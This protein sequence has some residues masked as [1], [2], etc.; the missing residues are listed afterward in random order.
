VNAQSCVPRGLQKRWSHKIL[1]GVNGRG[2]E[3]VR[4]H[5]Q[6]FQFF[7]EKADRN[8]RRKQP[9]F[10]PVECGYDDM[11]CEALFQKQLLKIVAESGV[12]ELDIEE[13]SRSKLVKDLG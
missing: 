10:I 11:L 4:L 5:D 1:P 13:T 3:F 12:L 7:R 2:V 8:F 9:Q 6:I